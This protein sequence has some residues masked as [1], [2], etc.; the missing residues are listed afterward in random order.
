MREPDITTTKTKGHENERTD[1]GAAGH[2]TGVV[3]T[4]PMF[5][6]HP[7]KI[8]SKYNTPQWQRYT[9]QEGT[10]AFPGTSTSLTFYLSA[11]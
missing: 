5:L 9:S 2:F 7:R 1:K 6:E 10:K 3:V 8:K 11:K 4:L